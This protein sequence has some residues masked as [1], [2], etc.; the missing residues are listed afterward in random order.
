MPVLHVSA[1]EVGAAMSKA[2][3]EERRT[4]QYG[5]LFEQA[6]CNGCKTCEIACKDYH[7]LDDELA[8]RTIYEYAG[9]SWS[10]DEQGAWSQDVYCYYLS[11]SCNHCSN[12]V[13]I[14]FCSSGAVTKDDRGFVTID[15]EMCMGC[16]QCMI[17]CP[18]HA[19]RFDERRGVVVKC[20]G[21]RDRIDA[22]K[23]PI[24]VEACPQRA[25][26]FGRYGDLPS[27]P[28]ATADIAPLSSSDLTQPNFLVEPCEIAR[29]N[30]DGTG[31]IVNL[32]EA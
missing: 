11:L 16:Q 2:A 12:P 17:A 3:N 4:V 20:D 14:R 28:D 19:P 30:G 22:G 15:R 7:G 24:C 9:G 29:D 8:L 18:Y 27:S 26:S 6:R 5:F 31:S 13:C 21:C 1:R 32:S 25:L 23:G 10:E